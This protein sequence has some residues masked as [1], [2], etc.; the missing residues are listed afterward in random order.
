LH[1]EQCFT[2]SD[3]ITGPFNPYQARDC[4]E[5]RESDPRSPKAPPLSNSVCAN[6]IALPG[7][8]QLE[9]KMSMISQSP[10]QPAIPNLLGGLV[11]QIGIG[12]D[13][14]MSYWARRAAIKAL[15]AL[16]D[17]ALRDIGIARCNIETAVLGGAANPDMG[18]L[19]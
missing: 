2:C 1:R 10:A 4:T 7:A 6:G 3:T 8:N 18:R 19:G 5:E 12:A 15:R 14:V 9:K 17:R 16:D 11:R 13:A